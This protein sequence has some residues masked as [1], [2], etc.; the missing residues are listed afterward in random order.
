ML[1]A[2]RGNFPT[3]RLLL[4]LSF[5]FSLRLF[6]CLKPSPLGLRKPRS[7]CVRALGN[8]GRRCWMKNPPIFLIVRRRKLM[9]PVPRGEEPAATRFFF[10]SEKNGISCGETNGD[11]FTLTTVQQS[12]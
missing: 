8:G 1:L 4:L 11:G 10:V 2:C 12:I 3:G 7:L 6:V 5:L 9:P